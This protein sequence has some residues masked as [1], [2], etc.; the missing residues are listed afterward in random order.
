MFHAS[1]FLMA[2]IQQSSG[3]PAQGSAAGWTVLPVHSVLPPAAASQPFQIRGLQTFLPYPDFAA[4]I[5]CLDTKRLGK[6]SNSGKGLLLAHYSPLPALDQRVEAY[7]IL[8]IVTGKATSKAW[9]N[10]PCVRMW[11]GHTKALYLYYNQCLQ[12]WSERGG[13]NVLLKPATL[14]GE[15]EMPPW[16]G[17]DMIHKS[18]RSMLLAKDAEHYGQFGWQDTPGSPYWW[19]VPMERKEEPMSGELKPRRKRATRAVGGVTQDTED[20]EAAAAE[21]TAR[22]KA[23]REERALARQHK[24]QTNVSSAGVLAVVEQA[25]QAMMVESS[26]SVAVESIAKLPSS[27]EGPSIGSEQA[28][29][30]GKAVLVMKEE[31]VLPLIPEVFQDISV[32][33]F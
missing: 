22:E 23:A 24:R 27:Q 7:Q 9:Q 5:K 30:T 8:N 16:L 4:S 12:E 11:R 1:R 14:D 2:R 28:A 6:Q 33:C 3:R 26:I 20:V 25:G 13:N 31:K 29:A 18:H 19:P 15:I 21:R 32:L 10:H 17:N